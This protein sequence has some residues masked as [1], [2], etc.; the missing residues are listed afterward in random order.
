MTPLP[1]IGIIGAGR[2]GSALG[3]LMAGLG[4]RLAAVA[5]RDAA[6][7]AALAAAV[8]A[9]VCASPADVVQRAEL[10]LLTVSDDAIDSTAATIASTLGYEAGRAIVHTSGSRDATTLRSL[11]ERG[12]RVGSLHPV[13][14][15]TGNVVPSLVGVAFAIEAEDAALKA[16]LTQIVAALEGVPIYIPPGKKAHYHAALVFAGNF[17]VVL[18]GLAERLLTQMGVE[19]ATIRVA[20]LP[21]MQGTLDNL[22]VQPPAAALP[23]PISRG[24]AGTLAAHLRVLADDEEARALYR[25]LALAALPL[26]EAR[27]V[28]TAAMRATIEA[29]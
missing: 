22:R 25:A 13:Y 27:G 19:D 6:A 23:G 8:D 18:Y 5:S 12:L 15:F 26:A 4:Y 9:Q 2:V 11:A 17:P 20:L 29:G 10:T 14:P 28:E 24:D 1:T 16:Q 3:R 21:L 7:A